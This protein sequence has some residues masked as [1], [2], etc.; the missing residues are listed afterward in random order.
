MSDLD[1]ACPKCG[2]KIFKTT[3]K[4][5]T[6]ADINNLVCAGCGY[7]LNE[8]EVREQARKFMRAQVSKMVRQ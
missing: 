8:L 4:L 7:K 1:F 5:K 3:T 6:A 2:K